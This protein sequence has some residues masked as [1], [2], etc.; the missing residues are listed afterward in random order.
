MQYSACLFAEL[1]AVE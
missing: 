1:T